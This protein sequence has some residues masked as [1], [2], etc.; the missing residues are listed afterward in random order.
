[1]SIAD[2]FFGVLLL[3]SCAYGG[4][5][6]LRSYAAG[7]RLGGDET[8]HGSGHLRSKDWSRWRGHAKIAAPRQTTTLGIFQTN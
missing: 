2:V 1:M 8:P 4:N 7:R 5:P 6:L 3:T